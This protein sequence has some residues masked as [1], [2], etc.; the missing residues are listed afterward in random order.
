MKMSGFLVLVCALIYGCASGVLRSSHPLQ[1]PALEVR[2]RPVGVWVDGWM[3][4]TDVM[5]YLTGS[6]A[7]QERARAVLEAAGFCRGKT[8][9]VYLSRSGMVIVNNETFSSMREAVH[10]IKSQHLTRIL[11]CDSSIFPKALPE[12]FRI[13]GV[14]LWLLDW[15][16]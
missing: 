11:F 12:G 7:E 2:A 3:Y 10:F 15:K 14:D 8:D 16:K 1:N 13:D 6:R 4:H 9:Y 5:E